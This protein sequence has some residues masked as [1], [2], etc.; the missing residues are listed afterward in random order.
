MSPELTSPQTSKPS[1][2][3]E[4]AE[5]AERLLGLAAD[6]KFEVAL[7]QR[8]EGQFS[9]G[10]LAKR[11]LIFQEHGLDLDPRSGPQRLNTIE[12]EDWAIAR[13]SETP[14]ISLYAAVNY[15]SEV[16]NYH[17]EADA[18]SR[19]NRSQP[20]DPLLAE[21]KLRSLPLIHSTSVE[22]FISL[23]RH[24]SFAS[25]KGLYRA[26]GQDALAF[27]EASKGSTNLGDR[28]LGLDQYVFADFGRPHRFHKQGEITLILDPAVMDQPGAFITEKD[29]ADCKDLGE[30]MQGATTPDYFYSQAA[31]RIEIGR[32]HV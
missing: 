9:D 19:N 10:D 12:E 1:Q 18:R 8:L 26:S 17:F 22:G 32:A 21:A 4:A 11:Q 29:A 23:V 30:Y 20:I 6:V 13:G 2:E 27:S 24:G 25:N 16:G 5:R 15:R 14:L 31:M 3:Q 28:E 7:A